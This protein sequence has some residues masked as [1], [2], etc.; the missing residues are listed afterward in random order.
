[1]FETQFQEFL[2]VAQDL[3]VKHQITRCNGEEIAETR[4]FEQLSCYLNFGNDMIEFS[5][6][7]QQQIWKQIKIERQA[8]FYEVTKTPTY[9]KQMKELPLVTNNTSNEDSLY[10]IVSLDSSIKDTLLSL[11]SPHKKEFQLKIVWSADRMK[12]EA[13]FFALIPSIE[14]K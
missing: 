7:V 5:F 13:V 14:Q 10:T 11:F 12:Y 8:V 2:L 3:R 6:K 4:T 1:M 9:R